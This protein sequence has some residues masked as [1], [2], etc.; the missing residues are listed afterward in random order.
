MVWWEFGIW[1]LVGGLL[2]EA[3]EFRSVARANWGLL[4]PAY[5]GWAFWTAEIIRVLGG[6]VLAVTLGQ[7]EIVVTP[8]SAMAIGI[9][10]PVIL[11]KLKSAPIAPPE[12]RDN[13]PAAAFPNHSVDPGDATIQERPG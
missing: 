9:L 12:Q 5:T 6:G 11:D 13:A 1:G 2:I 7:S 4:P 10:T 3:L 8:V